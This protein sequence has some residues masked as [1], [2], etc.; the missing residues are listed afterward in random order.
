MF[1]FD[2]WV[3]VVFVIAFI[4]FYLIFDNLKIEYIDTTLNK[5]LISLGLAGLCAAGYSYLLASGSEIPITADFVKQ[6][7]SATQSIEPAAAAL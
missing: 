1:Y 3:A 6:G 5:V 2:L 7:A 4:A